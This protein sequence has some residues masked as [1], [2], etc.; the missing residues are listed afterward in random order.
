MNTYKTK[1]MECNLF[2]KCQFFKTNHIEL[3]ET[4]K[5][6]CET[7]LC[8]EEYHESLLKLSNN[9]TLGLMVLV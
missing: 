4:E 6:I 2:K 9:K 3:N 5:E 8:L 7:K 1:S